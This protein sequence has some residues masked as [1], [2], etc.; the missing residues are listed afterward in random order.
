MTNTITFVKPPAMPE[1]P[2]FQGRAGVGL[3]SLL[4]GIGLALLGLVLI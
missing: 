4:R 2:P 3:S 1:P